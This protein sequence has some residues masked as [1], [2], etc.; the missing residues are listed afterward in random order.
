MTVLAVARIVVAVEW[1]EADEKEADERA[2]KVAPRRSWSMRSVEN[3]SPVRM[4]WYC[5]TLR[6]RTTSL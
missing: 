2:V 5:A 1:L 4:Y 3:M 6:E